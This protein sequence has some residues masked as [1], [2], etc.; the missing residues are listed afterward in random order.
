MIALLFSFLPQIESS[1]SDL[2]DYEAKYLQKILKT[3]NAP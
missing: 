2:E 1:S 3:T